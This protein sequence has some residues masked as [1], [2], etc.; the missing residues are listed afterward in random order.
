MVHKLGSCN[1]MVLC[2]LTITK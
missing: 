2:S 1:S